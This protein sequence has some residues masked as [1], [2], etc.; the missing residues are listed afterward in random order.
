MNSGK[1]PLFAV[2]LR[3]VEVV[4]VIVASVELTEERKVVIGSEGPEKIALMPSKL[5]LLVV[6]LE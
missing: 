2:E 6:R 4:Q 5:P 3:R 1:S